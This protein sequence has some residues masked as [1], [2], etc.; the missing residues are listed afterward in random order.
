MLETVIVQCLQI[1]SVNSLSV[2]SLYLVL[3]GV[4]SSCVFSLLFMLAADRRRNCSDEE[5]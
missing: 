2:C 3:F 1:L 4:L 5:P